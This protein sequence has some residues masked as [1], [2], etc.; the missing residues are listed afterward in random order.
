MMYKEDSFHHLFFCH[1][2]LMN[3]LNNIHLTYL[4]KKKKNPLNTHF[5]KHNPLVARDHQ[6]N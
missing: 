3:D 4:A 1:I 2:K 5:W 6:I